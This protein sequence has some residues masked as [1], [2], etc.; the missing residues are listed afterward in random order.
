LAAPHTPPRFR[1]LP[2]F[3]S[4]KVDLAVALPETTAA[5]TVIAALSTAGKGLVERC[6]LFDVYRGASLGA[7]KKSLAFHVLLQASDRTLSDQDCAKYL[8]RAERALTELGGELRK[9]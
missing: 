1:S 3:P 5:G 6:E 7:G 8:Q 4:V 9:A 2:K